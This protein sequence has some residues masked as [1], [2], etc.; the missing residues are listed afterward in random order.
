[1]LYCRDS[2]LQNFVIK[3]PLNYGSNVPFQ[4]NVELRPFDERK[5][6]GREYFQ[7]K[8]GGKLENISR[9]YGND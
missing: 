4:Q 3:L 7:N 6:F 8:R 2:C 1:M 5:F 9:S